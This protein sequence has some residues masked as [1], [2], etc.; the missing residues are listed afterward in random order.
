MSI[1]DGIIDY[2]NRLDICSS[3]IEGR[4]ELLRRSC[5][6]EIEIDREGG[7]NSFK[8]FDHLGMEWMVRIP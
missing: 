8:F 7:S 4:T 3:A 1:E 6:R 5:T 2:V